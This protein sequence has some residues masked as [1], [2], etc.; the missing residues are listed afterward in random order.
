MNILIIDDDPAKREFIASALMKQDPTNKIRWFD[1]LQGALLFLNNNAS[2]VDLI[3]L[4][5]CFPASE[6]SRSQYAMGR[7]FLDHMVFN[8]LTNKVIIC[9]GDMVSVDKEKYPFVLG[10]L[11]FWTGMPFSENLTNIMNSE[12]P[13]VKS[14]NE[15]SDKGP[16]LKRKKQSQD[17]G[18][19]RHRSSTPWWQK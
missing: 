17:T 6:Y 2:Y 11:V 10:S 13:V 15:I 8:G 5:W 1:N 16:C 14:I 18:Y 4:D 9:S 7:Q 19:K 3:F 12:E